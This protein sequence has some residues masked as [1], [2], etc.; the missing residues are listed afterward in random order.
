M[1]YYENENLSLARDRI[2]VCQVALFITTHIDYTYPHCRS[3]HR[4]YS[5]KKSVLRNLAKFTGKNLC[6]SLFFNK[7]EG[8]RP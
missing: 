6:Q 5:V 1:G 2:E 4:R 8:L 3:S 7:V